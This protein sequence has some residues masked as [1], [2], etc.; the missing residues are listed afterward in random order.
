M[1]P[2][3]AG[4]SASSGVRLGS[5][6]SGRTKKSCPT[7]CSV[8]SLSSSSS[9]LPAVTGSKAPGS[10]WT[11]AS[12]AGEAPP[13]L[14]RIPSTPAAMTMA[15]ARANHFRGMGPPPFQTGFFQSPIIPRPTP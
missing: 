1:T 9:A 5:K 15:R 14:P 3:P 12:W 7:F 13:L 4:S 10:S 2:G 6:A 8:V 11:G